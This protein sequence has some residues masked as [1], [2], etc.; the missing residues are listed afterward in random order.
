MPSLAPAG[1]SLLLE[2]PALALSD[3]MCMCSVAVQLGARLPGSNK[4]GR[5]LA[6]AQ[7]DFRCLDLD[8]VTPRNGRIEGFV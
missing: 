4:P 7:L 2:T 6:P 1:A 3:V 5:S 8:S